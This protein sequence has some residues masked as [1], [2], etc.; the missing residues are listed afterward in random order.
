MEVEEI[1]EEPEV[2]SNVSWA[3]QNCNGENLVGVQMQSFGGKQS[4]Y[5]NPSMGESPASKE[6]CIDSQYNILGYKDKTF[7]EDNNEYA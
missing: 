6:A 4:S 2:L 7:F 3:S 5:W 1:V